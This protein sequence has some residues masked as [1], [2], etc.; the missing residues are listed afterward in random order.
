M[1]RWLRV[2][3]NRPGLRC[4]VENR[5][6]F[7]LS[8]II[9]IPYLSCCFFHLVHILATK[10]SSFRQKKNHLS[11]DIDE[12]AESPC[13][14]DCKNL[15][16]SYVC[17][18]V[19][20]AEKEEEARQESCPPGY[21]WDSVTQLCTDIDECLE[22][23]GACNEE[24]HLCVNTQGS[25]TCHE[26]SGPKGCPAGFK[27]DVAT[28]LCKDVDECAE[29]IHGC[30]P[31]AEECRNI[32]GGY[33]CDMK[34]R[35]GFAFSHRLGLC[36]DIDECTESSHPCP[37][38]ETRCV[39]KVGSYECR[40][41]QKL[42]TN[43]SKIMATGSSGIPADCR[44]GKGENVCPEKKENLIDTKREK[45]GGKIQREEDWPKEPE[46]AGSNYEKFVIEDQTFSDPSSSMRNN[47]LDDETFPSNCPPGSFYNRERKT[48][49]CHAGFE[50][51]PVNGECRDPSKNA[52]KPILSTYSEGREENPCALGYKRDSFGCVDIDECSEGPG[53]QSNERC[54][55]FPGG[56]NCAPLCSDGWRWEGRRKSCIDVDECLE[57]L[58][59]CPRETHRCVN[60]NGTYVCEELESCKSGYR[61]IYNGSCIDI[62]ECVE[63]PGCREHERCKNLP[64][65]YDCE[66][67]C[68]KGW[69]FDPSSKGCSDIDE[70]LLGLH[71]CPQ[72][73]HRCVNTNG[74]YSCQLIPPCTPGFRKMFNGS[75]VDIDECLENLHDCKLNYHRY[76]VNREGT[77]ECVTRYPECSKG[78]EYSLRSRS[79][80]DIDE[81]SRGEY[82]CDAR[83]NEK[84]VNLPG[85]YKCER[86]TFSSH[87]KRQKPACPNGYR[88]DSAR[89]ECT[90]IDE[91]AEGLDSCGDEVCYNQPGGYSCARTPAP[92]PMKPIR[93]PANQEKPSA[94]ENCQPGMRYM[95]NRG[96]LDVN[97]CEEDDEACSSNE[98]CVN[99]PGSFT[100]ECKLGFRRD[101]LTQAC[102]DIN[103]CQL[104][105]NDCLSTQRCDNTLGSYNC[106]RYLP[107]GTGYTLN[108]A[109]EICEDDD[110]CV[111]GT[112]DCSGGYHCRNTL[113]S[114]RCDKNPRSSGSLASPRTAPVTSRIYATTPSSILS[115]GPRGICPRGFVD[116]PN[117]RC[118]DVDE[119]SRSVNPCARS[120]Q[121]CVNTLGSYKCVS[122]VLCGNGYTLD[123]ESNSHCVD[124]DECAEGTHDCRKGQTCRN[125]QGGYICECPP[126]HVTGP[127]KD[128][129]DIDECSI[130]ASQSYG[131]VCG[132]N[133]RCEN[134][135]GSFRCVCESGFENVAHGSGVCQDVDE[136]ARSP[137][138]CQHDCVNAWGSYRCT[139]KP[140]FRLNPD[141]RS[142][143]DI[144]E[145]VEFKENNL[146]IGIC[147]NTP[148]SYACSCP[149]GYKL[150]P[151]GRTCQ[152]M[153]E[154]A[155]GRVCRDPSEMCQNTRGSF[156]CNRIDCPTGYYRDRERKNR[157]VRTS[158]YCP[159]GDLACFRAP[160]HF[161][162]NFITFVSMLPIPST[163]IL[164]L[165][166][167]RGTH[168]PGSTV[169]FSMALVDAR[170]P[171]GVTRATESCFALRRPTPSQAV[172][173]LTRSIPGPQE[174][175]LDLSMEIYHNAAFAGSAVAKLFIYVSQYE[176]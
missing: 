26:L 55:N 27:F 109:T 20:S 86:P 127:N 145:C 84:C 11:Q 81:C 128:C 58:D 62:D 69:R 75:C 137:G 143:T 3:Q 105:E 149:N 21:Q 126:G 158:R 45:A 5:A 165:F 161:S 32:E 39:N 85:S 65:R 175:E 141:N 82:T 6:S 71:D 80:Q 38:P 46:A 116:G 164:E 171:P 96:C 53:C 129:V 174:I 97:E 119:C 22:L 170:A 94:D 108:A 138:L 89:R 136:C 92:I 35:K 33:E 24:S 131:G 168:L 155:S 14:G 106:V 162:Y 36:L 2:Q 51:D 157:C 83:F 76:C 50:I 146:C 8:L 134:T 102:V 173:V 117:G 159:S 54:T 99:T 4:V 64:G 152:D 57:A 166:T 142:C 154:C 144:D 67:L 91:C 114:Y 18:K 13:P 52:T 48:C 123:P 31:E 7:T 10:I 121:K 59:D 34:C 156:R 104:L 56:Y 172:L 133:A 12:C 169:Q 47:V 93:Q 37:D 60:K 77:Y 16:G 140:G 49:E 113:G 87:G 111:L 72:S 176:F 30:L 163:G 110:E 95:R 124:V 44:N 139:C 79:C 70:C 74:T 63:G 88:Y 107:C 40:K 1:S 17:L 120:L 42:A 28:R 43:V 125:R 29:R 101:N 41:S 112:H 160:S 19:M 9:C 150:S 115:T 100:C 103:E 153:D 118:I 151:D 98:Q 61:R 167:M 15:V 68:V 23:S 147:E 132:T 73:S 122:R 25:F 78:F 130:Y 148:G 135:V 66:L 90:D